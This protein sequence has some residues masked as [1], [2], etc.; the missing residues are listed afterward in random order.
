MIDKTHLQVTGLTLELLKNIEN[1][2][3]ITLWCIS[4]SLIVISIIVAIWL[5]G[6][7]LLRNY[8]S[9]QTKD[10]QA[11]F[12]VMIQKLLQSEN[13]PDDFEIP[14]DIRTDRT[15]V[16]AAL[17]KFFKLIKGDDATRLK[18]II[19]E[20]H[21]EPIVQEA[22]TWGN[23]GKRMRAFHVLSFMDSSSSLRTCSKHLYSSDK[24]IRLSVARCIARRRVMSLI[25]EVAEAIVYTFPKDEKILAD[26][27]YRFGRKGVPRIETLARNTKNPTIKTAVLET[28]I[29]L[30]PET[31]S[32]DL[33]EFLANDDPRVRAAAVDLSTMTRGLNHRDLLLDGLADESRT[34]KIRSLKVASK[35]NRK[36]TF[37]DLYRL[38]NDPFMWVRY[39]AM[40]AALKT[41]RS[42]ET[43]MR[44]LS[45]QGGE[46]GDLA[47]DVLRER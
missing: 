2:L 45:R 24:Y 46:I 19:E 29:L 43:L 34:V 33:N 41:G 4:A 20:L 17:L 26:V 11:R 18:M 21:L 32:L 1:V 5:S 36:E 12:E 47:L 28:L 44:S 40:Q 15:A 7:R 13:I 42:G 27:L 35:E 38:M 31:T 37:A 3:L 8:R 10:R 9:G 22:V 23:R 30:R 25:S 16:T 6:R 39:W 14:N